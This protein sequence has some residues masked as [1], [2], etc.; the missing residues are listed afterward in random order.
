M[1]GK[2]KEEMT[3]LSI[4]QSKLGS[5][6]ES[7]TNVLIGI[8]F[9]FIANIV[10]LPAFGYMVTF[11]DGLLISVVFTIISIFRSYVI[12]RIYNKYNFFGCNND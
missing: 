6:S 1:D 4:K 12:R 8:S 2:D 7:V 11:K 10:V 5:L 9:G 3:K